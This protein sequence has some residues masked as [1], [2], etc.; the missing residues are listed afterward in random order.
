MKCALC[1]GEWVNSEHAWIHE[2]NN[3]PLANSFFHIQPVISIINAA[4][5]KAKE[6]KNGQT[7][8]TSQIK[9]ELKESNEK[10]KCSLCSVEYIKTG[11]NFNHPLVSGCPM[12]EF[13]D[14][15]EKEGGSLCESDIKQM[16]KVIEA[17]MLKGYN[18]GLKMGLQKGLE[19]DKR[20][21][22]NC[23]H[24]DNTNLMEF[25]HLFCRN[26]NGPCAVWEEK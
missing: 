25:C 11:G 22:Q 23:K 10:I 21:R 2:S 16:N 3:C 26:C 9:N 20:K 7:N 24:W 4:I 15:L 13:S 1:G 17:G 14:E 8:K 19:L 6:L 5:E 12:S 18:A